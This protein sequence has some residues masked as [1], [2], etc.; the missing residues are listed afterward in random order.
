M[1]ELWNG[2]AEVWADTA[3]LLGCAAR[4]NAQLRRPRCVRV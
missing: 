2:V 4:G 1:D 3:A